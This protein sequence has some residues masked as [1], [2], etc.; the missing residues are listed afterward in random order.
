MSSTELRPSLALPGP[1]RAVVCDMDGLLVR[2]DPTWVRAKVILF[3]RHGVEFH[4]SDQRAVFGAAEIHSATYFTRR[5]GLPESEIPAVRREYMDIVHE[6][7]REPV[8]INQGAGELLERLSGR[9]PLGLAS[10]TRRTLVDEVLGNTPF[11]HLFDAITTGDETDPKPAPGVYLLACE[12]LGVHPSEAVALED[13]PVGVQA[14]KA[15]GMSCIGIPSNLQEPL[16]EA[17]Y[18]LDSLTRLL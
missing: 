8:E 3:E 4:D 15:A 1:W 17:D 12:R 16:T 9:V 2:T 14:A 11:G 6:L 7:F 18:Q 13:S 5:F 10:N